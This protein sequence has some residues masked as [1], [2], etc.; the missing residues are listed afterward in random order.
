MDGIELCV[1]ENRERAND[2]QSN[3]ERNRM[4]RR[5]TL[6]Q[7]QEWASESPESDMHRKNSKERSTESRREGR[8]ESNFNDEH[9]RK[10]IAREQS[11]S[12]HTRNEPEPKRTRRASKREGYRALR[13]REERISKGVVLDQGCQSRPRVPSRPRVRRDY[14]GDES[15]N[16]YQDKVQREYIRDK[17]LLSDL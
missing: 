15:S 13:E 14:D 17:S 4:E 6:N 10:P 8:I 1:R 11:R 9:H 16:I 5:A 2:R 12:I 3:E 7:D